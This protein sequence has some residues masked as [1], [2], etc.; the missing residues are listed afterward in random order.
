MEKQGYVQILPSGADKRTRLAM[1]SDTGRKVWEEH[2]QFKIRRYYEEALHGFSTDD[3]IHS[4]H[5][6][7]R[8]LENMKRIDAKSQADSL[9]SPELSFEKKDGP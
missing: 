2:A 4:L 1:P 5:Y 7:L 6:L 3:I 9:E 8:I